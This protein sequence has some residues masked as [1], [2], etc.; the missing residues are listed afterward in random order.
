MSRFE[1]RLEAS[2]Q[3]AA[4]DERDS[5]AQERIISAALARV[6][7][8]ERSVRRA[9]IACLA[10]A[11]AA[12]A[13]VTALNLF[14]VVG[15]GASDPTTNRPLIERLPI[16]PPKHSDPS[17]SFDGPEGLV[18]PGE[19]CAEAEFG[20]PSHLDTNVP[21]WLP[22]R[23]SGFEATRSW[24]CGDAPVVMVSDIQLSYEPGWENVDVKTKWERMARESGGEF[25]TVL[26]QPA[27]IRAA[28]TE[29]EYHQVLVVV[30]GTLIN[31]LAP[32][33]VPIEGLV[34]LTNAL[35]AK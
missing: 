23:E 25:G 28:A 9:L 18:G 12:L 4:G 8:R 5:L 17:A 1:Q 32:N 2:L 30:N 13:G 20:E 14:G 34:A 15:S 6:E 33:S 10:G 19:P 31:A 29:S 7:R 22:S 27:L 3:D 16:V 24:T 21:V 11:A 26:S 35:V